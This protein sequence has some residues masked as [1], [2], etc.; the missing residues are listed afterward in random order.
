M[1]S[2]DLQHILDHFI[3][4]AYSSGGFKPR[5][6]FLQLIWLCSVW[7]IW[8]ER[9]H[10]LFSNNVKQIMEILQKVKITSL[11]WLKSKVVCFPFGYHMWW[12]QP[13][14]CLGIG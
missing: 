5:R 1:H 12:L 7:V 6:S 11:P 14:V 3:Q 2:V 9:N 13:L 8:N 4:S 10:M